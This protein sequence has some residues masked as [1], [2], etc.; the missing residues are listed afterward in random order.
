MIHPVDM[1]LHT[2]SNILKPQNSSILSH[3][4]IPRHFVYF[5]PQT[6]APP[7]YASILQPNFSSSPQLLLKKYTYANLRISS[8][9]CASTTFSSLNST[10]VDP[11]ALSG[12]G[13]RIKAT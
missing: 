12:F 4:A 10:H 7:Y 6:H 3:H 13:L 5:K 1:G 8:T 9:S 2:S 11:V